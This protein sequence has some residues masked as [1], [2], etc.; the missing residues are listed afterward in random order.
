MMFYKNE[1]II[2]LDLSNFDTINVKSM[3]LMLS[4]CISLTSLNIAN[5]NVDNCS[6]NYMSIL[7]KYNESLV[8]YINENNTKIISML[9]E[10]N[11]T[12]E[13]L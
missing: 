11:I 5:F 1:K 6:S 4:D 2:S 13:Y 12:F 8:V 9:E 10:K 7:D 3:E